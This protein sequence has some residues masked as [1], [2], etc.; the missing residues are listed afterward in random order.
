M[1]GRPNVEPESLEPRQLGFIVLEV[2]VQGDVMQRR[3]IRAE[4][5]GLPLQERPL[6]GVEERE[7]LRI[8]SVS[9]ADLEEHV[10]LF[11]PKHLEPDDVLVERAHGCQV[12]DANGHLP[13]SSDRSDPS[14]TPPSGLSQSVRESKAHGGCPAAPQLAPRAAGRAPRDRLSAPGSRATTFH[15]KE[16]RCPRFL[17]TTT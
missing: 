5:L 10:T 3:L 6:A 2:D 8:P 7:V 15:A 17:A 11:S 16:K 14:P 1:L 4:R 12:I 13:E 9:L